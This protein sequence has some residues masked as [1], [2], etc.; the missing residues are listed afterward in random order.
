M[1]AFERA[2]FSEGASM[3]DGVHSPVVMSLDESQDREAKEPPH[4][5]RV[6]FAGRP[7]PE[8]YRWFADE[9]RFLIVNQGG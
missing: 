5:I 7:L 2:R 4:D 8:I 9:R 6:Q 3:G 1:G